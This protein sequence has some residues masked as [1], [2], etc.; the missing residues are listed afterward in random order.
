MFNF[1]KFSLHFVSSYYFNFKYKKS[2]SSLK[3]TK[4]YYSRG[5]TLIA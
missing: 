5:T 1:N 3:G 2:P 4:D